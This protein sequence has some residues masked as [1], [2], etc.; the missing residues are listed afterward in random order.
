[1]PV[2]FAYIFVV[3]IWATTPLAIQWSNSSL[4]FVA[5]V[6]VRMLMALVVCS[7]LMLVF[8]MKLIKKRSDWFVFLAGMIGLYPNMLLVYWSAQFISSG[9]MAVILGL[10]PFA[11]GLFSLLL[12]KENVFNP[13]R[14]VAVV[15]ALTG[16]SVIHLEQ[17]ALSGDG[18]YG[19]MG[20]VASAF[21]F[22]LSSVWVKAI[23]ASVNPLRQSTGVLVLAV[24]ALL[25]TWFFIDGKLPQ[26]IDQRSL[27]GVSYLAIAGS[28]IGHTLFYYV[29]RTCSMVSVSL[30][31]L[32]TP[33]M[34]LSIGAVVANERVSSKTI[35]GSALV[36]LSLAVYHGILPLLIRKV[37]HAG[38]WSSYL[39]S[40]VTFCRRQVIA[41]AKQVM[42]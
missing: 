5:A 14:I 21:L 16:L 37:R 24:P 29:L 8:R 9:L 23:G 34:A 18:I 41:F 40:Y 3:F 19:V 1:M 35:L 4:N 20:M 13:R 22:A 17:L 25:I 15:L 12:L 30:I 2:I 36:L 38:K 6:S 10:Y 42:F 31:P 7:V 39:L 33:V 27:L 26:E 11:V 28:V 32:I